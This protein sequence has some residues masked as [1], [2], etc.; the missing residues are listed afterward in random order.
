MNFLEVSKKKLEEIKS[1]FNIKHLYIY[2]DE[3]INNSL[4]E[5]NIHFF[6]T[7]NFQ[8]QIKKKKIIK[9]EIERLEKIIEEVELVSWYNITTELNKNKNY[10]LHLIISIKS[11]IGYNNVIEN[12]IKFFF[13]NNYEIDTKTS[14]CWNFLDI[15]KSW[16][17]L[18]K[19]YENK[20]ENKKN[21]IKIKKENTYYADKLDPIFEENLTKKNKSKINILKIKKNDEKWFLNIKKLIKYKVI[22]EKKY[23]FLKGIKI[24]EKNLNERQLIFLWDYFL[25][26]NNMVIYKDKI[27]K[28]EENYMIAYKEF[29]PLDFLYDEINY[30]FYFFRKE[31][32][33][34]FNNFNELDFI[35][36]FLKNK[37]EK[38][39]RFKEFSSRKI[40]FNF[41]IL[42][43]KDGIYSILHNKFIRTNKFNKNNNE[44][45]E[46]LLINR[47]IS[48]IKFYNYSYENLKE[49]EL[50][51]NSIEK[52]LGLKKRTNSLSDKIA[53]F[54]K[55][56]D[57]KWLL[58][59]I[60][61]I[62]HH[63]TNELN[64]KNTLY[65]WGQSNTGKTTLIINLFINYFGKE[66][67]GLISNNKNF[68]YQHLIN[69]NLLIFDEFD[70]EKINIEN[71]KKLI[72][73]ELIL[74]EK[75]NKEPELI[76]PTPMLI[77]SNYNL[78]N[79]LNF[80]DN[81]QAILNRLK[82][83]NFKEKFEENEMDYNINEKLKKEEAK[84]IVYC[85]RVYF[86]WIKKGKK[87]RMDDIKLIEKI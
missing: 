57:I 35:T 17:Y 49:P 26:I 18:Y 31:F 13:I 69:K 50:W 42:E 12:N 77:S 14:I 19:D 28:K 80:N 59:Y 46:N 86:N 75:K 58:I 25:L 55:E 27:Y 37:P 87:N 21:N 84:I 78:E 67:I 34:Q 29:E 66:N 64:K 54:I 62:F 40:N 74:G 72:S 1:D 36:K 83:I 82:S 11:L 41:N 44:K 81:K 61:Y 53:K 79:K 20:N 3:V 65:I 51:L 5:G 8:E 68:E 24:E 15:K 63:S 73:K 60:A 33:F 76:E 9:K 32:K 16:R 71:F 4:N 47:E 48:T 39:I 7:V 6:I 2:M 85:N 10:H 43:F 56:D 30:I 70:I 52:V 38:L 23:D 22:D 45:L